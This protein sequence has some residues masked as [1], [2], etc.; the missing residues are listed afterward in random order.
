MAV[1]KHK[2]I[3][4]IIVEGIE[5]YWVVKYENI[6]QL[7]GIMR[8]TVGLVE[9]SNYRFCFF[10]TVDASHVQ[11]HHNYIE[12]KYKIKAITPSLIKAAI[13]YAN[14]HV[15]WKNTKNTVIDSSLEGF[16]HP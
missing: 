8:C 7:E 15:I 10:R 5:Y 3:R 4:K 11:Y 2:K 1:P 13:L 14:E 6:D 9:Q 12:E 16:S